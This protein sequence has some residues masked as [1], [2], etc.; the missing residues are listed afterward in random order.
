MRELPGPR[1]AADPY[2]RHEMR[3]WDGG[4]W[5]AHVSDRGVTGLDSVP[6]LAAGAAAAEASTSVDVGAATEA[7]SADA[8]TQVVPAA[9]SGTARQGTIHDELTIALPAATADARRAASVD[10]LFGSAAVSA[11]TAAPAYR[12][13]PAVG[14][15]RN[16]LLIGIGALAVTGLVAGVIGFSGLPDSGSNSVTPVAVPATTA[17]PE[18]TTAE[19]EPTVTEEP[20]MY[21]G[22]TTSAVDEPTE[23]AAR[24]TTPKPPTKKP[25]ASSTRPRTT[26]STRPS[27][28]TRPVEIVRYPGCPA[29]HQDYPHGVGRPGARDRRNGSG[30]D[31]VRNFTVNGP[32]YLANFRLDFD[33]D[34]IACEA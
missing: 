21:G 34:G 33:G 22:P 18:P 28:R 4:G 2:G 8:P 14:G 26:T 24:T 3:Y 25:S 17:A 7:G 13:A 10:A 9:A 30:G 15:R 32:L 12:T 23:P 11:K 29:M 5:T 27:T 1:W 6:G 19:P 31:R 20:T 16:G